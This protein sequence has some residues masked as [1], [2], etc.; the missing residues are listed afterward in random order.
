MV[1]G[2]SKGIG[3]AC[4]LA[5]AAN[6]AKVIVNY[7]SSKDEASEVVK[8]I[9]EGGGEAFLYKA[10]VR[11]AGKI[12]E[13]VGRAKERFGSLDILVNNAGVLLDGGPLASINVDAFAPV[14]NV[15]VTGILNCC[16]AAAPVMKEGG[17][18]SIV[19]IASVAG[20]GTASRPGN[21]LYSSTK[22]AVIILTKNLALD[23]GSFGVRVNAV[24]PGLIRTDMGLQGK[25]ADEQDERLAYYKDHSILGRIG[26]P[27]EIAEAVAF[28]ASD[29][30]SFIT[31]QTLTVDGGR[32]DFLSHSI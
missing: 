26:E 1:T 9:Y 13:M 19:N 18:G 12:E 7:N 23:L 15:N 28:L 21:I 2:A 11:D 31:G 14:W 27:E 10:D 17:K 8:R 32:I 22:A 24:A 5:M 4:A 25:P 30:A 20:I 6:G 29:K 16:R 3:R